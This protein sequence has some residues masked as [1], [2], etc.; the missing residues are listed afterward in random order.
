MADA[1]RDQTDGKGD[2]PEDDEFTD[3][4]VSRRGMLAYGGGS[5]LLTWGAAGAGWFTFIYEPAGPEE[6]LVREYVGALDRSNFYTVAGLFHEDAPV[7]PPTVRDFPDIQEV[8]TSID[9]TEVV[10]RNEDVALETVQE[11]ALV[12]AEM[13][14]DSPTEST[15]IT[16][17]FVVAQNTDGDWKMWRESISES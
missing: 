14:V 2:K 13:T 10:E 15:T 5:A 9:S 7:S 1:P 12:R 16:H 11:M 8:D 17:G 6:E 4:S 3:K